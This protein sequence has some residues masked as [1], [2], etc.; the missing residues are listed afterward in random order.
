MSTVFGRT[1]EPWPATWLGL[2]APHDGGEAARGRLAEAAVATGAPLDVTQ[3]PSLWGPLLRGAENRTVAFGGRGIEAARDDSHAADLV[4]ADLIGLLS[5]LGRPVLDLFFLRVR[6]AIEE[7]QLNGALMAL[8]SAR[9]EGLVRHVGLSCEGPPLAALGLWQFHDAFVA[10]ALPR[11]P[12]RQEA[13]AT[14][15]PLAQQ[16]RVGLVSFG[17][18]DWGVGLP[19]TVLEDGSE[20]LVPDA[21]EANRS[22]GCVLVGVRTPAEVEA[23]LAQG[24]GDTDWSGL[25]LRYRDPASW[26]HVAQNDPRVWVRQAARRAAGAAK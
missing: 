9:E 12:L 3:G 23:A 17:A 11:N 20:R 13:F 2:M 4:S 7:Y 6:R 22:D 16:R 25:A 19:F 24:R 5:S 10:L 14:L 26:A 21:L 8:E 18:L 1:N 15:A